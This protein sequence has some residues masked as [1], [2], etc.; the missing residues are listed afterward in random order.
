MKRKYGNYP[1]W[2]RVLRR[3]YAKTYIDQCSFKGYVTLLNM[4]EVA[5]PLMVNYGGKEICIADNGYSWLQHF[6]EHQSFSLST[7]FNEHGEIMQWYIDI[8]FE[9]GVEDGVPWMD[10]LYLD[11]VILPGG[12]VIHL[13]IDEL[14]DAL[15]DSIITEK[16][17]ELAWEEFNRINRLIDR[18]EFHLVKLAHVHK[19]MLEQILE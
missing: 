15:T 16:Q 5:E 1:N 11:I 10:D 6:P 3:E 17:Y 8:C 2:K 4:K 9:I 14:E 7:I 19:Q 13:D 12:E 18:G